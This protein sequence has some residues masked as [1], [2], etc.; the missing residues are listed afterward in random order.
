MALLYFKNSV[1]PDLNEYRAMAVA[2]AKHLTRFFGTLAP[3]PGD[4]RVCLVSDFAQHGSLLHFFE[5]ADE[6]EL[7]IS[8]LHKLTI[9]RQAGD[10]LHSLHQHDLVHADVAARNVLVYSFD[11]T[12]HHNTLVK[13][14]DYGLVREKSDYTDATSSAT[15]DQ[16]IVGD[17][18]PLAPKWAAW[19]SLTKDKFYRASDVWSFAV[20]VW[21]ILS[22]G[23]KPYQDVGNTI[24]AMKKWLKSGHRLEQP[25][26]ADDALWTVMLQCW[27]GKRKE[28]PSLDAVLTQLA[29]SLEQAAVASTAKKLDEATAKLKAMEA[30]QS[31]WSL[32]AFG[33]RSGAIALT[34]EL[35]AELQYA[36]EGTVAVADPY[37][38]EHGS[39]AQ[40]L[41]LAIETLA[42][43]GGAQGRPFMASVMAIAI[44][45]N[46][47]LIVAFN[48]RLRRL[49]TQREKNKGTELFN[50]RWDVGLSD[51]ESEEK[52]AVYQRL[53]RCFIN[54]DFAS[55]GGVKIVLMWHGVKS[56]AA[57]DAILASG[58][59]SRVSGEDEGFF[60]KG[61]YLTSQAEYAAFYANNQNQPKR[62]E[63]YTLLLCAVC[64]ANAYPVTRRV[65]YSANS[66]I[67]KFHFHHGDEHTAKALK[68]GFDAHF[69]AV[70]K[71]EGYQAATLLEGADFDEL[72][73]ASEEQVL[74]FAKV[75]VLI[76]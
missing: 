45:K 2:K 19:E 1:G 17:S 34:P 20:L 32:P 15:A 26:D 68:G 28:R 74:P 33:W 58:L 27:S 44:A 6:D 66:D 52:R 61:V 39:K 51:A 36:V 46:Q 72:V 56:E 41:A 4:P 14:S 7:E 65:D 10:G 47:D 35:D 8:L 13:L 9:A 16:G 54:T 59:S 5:C 24:S 53:E 31:A 76:K 48:T 64:I 11:A 38:G 63:T 21:E 40:S 57:A 23:E 49:Q 25:D 60:G 62:G 29:Q 69:A 50:G 42:G 12:N 70:S 37:S 43:E 3:G 18:A 55:Q 71:A 73:V 22:E 30:I 75:K 67:S